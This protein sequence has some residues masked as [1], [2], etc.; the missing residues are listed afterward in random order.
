[1]QDG[2][3]L[4]QAGYFIPGYV[5]IPQ[6]NITLQVFDEMRLVTGRTEDFLFFSAASFATRCRIVVDAAV[7]VN[8]VVFFW[9]GVGVGVV[10][11]GGGC[12]IGVEGIFIA[13]AV[14]V[15]I[16]VGKIRIHVQRFLYNRPKI[17]ST[18]FTTKRDRRWFTSNGTSMRSRSE[19]KNLIIYLRET[20]N[21]EEQEEVRR[22][23]S[24]RNK[25]DRYL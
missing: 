8:A 3:G 7:F 22:V 21:E 9:S 23:K 25:S 6:Q 11:G 13:A 2:L 10:G 19:K 12:S 4:V 5:W 16:V 14:V 24:S 17:E 1:M 18:T 20:K 15:V